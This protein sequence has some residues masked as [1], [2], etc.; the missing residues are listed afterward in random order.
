MEGRKAVSPA[1]KEPSYLR[2]LSRL[3]GIKDL[4]EAEIM[5]VSE[6]LKIVNDFKSNW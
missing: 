4:T 6:A 2:S 5:V 3:M 1:G